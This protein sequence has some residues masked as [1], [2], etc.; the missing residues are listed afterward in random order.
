VSP[1]AQSRGHAGKA[2]AVAIAGVVFAVGLAFGVSVLASKGKVDVRLGDDQFSD[3]QTANI[4][5]AIAAHGPVFYSDLGGGD[6]PLYVQHLGKDADTGWLAFNALVPGSKTCLI[7]W[8]DAK[9]L[10]V[11]VCDPSRTWPPDGTGLD[12]YETKV[13]KGRLIVYLNKN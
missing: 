13:V 12:T 8:E 4:A 6:R 3:I 2:L 1:V 11:S 10:F 5:K 7:Q 9:R